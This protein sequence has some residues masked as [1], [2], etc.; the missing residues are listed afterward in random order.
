MK[1]I[2]SLILYI[3]LYAKAQ[4]PLIS[5]N[6]GTQG[7]GNSQIELSNGIGYHN[8]HR[9]TET[10]SEFSGVYSYGVYEKTDLVISIPFINKSTL[11]DSVNTKTAGFSD[12]S[13]EIKYRFLS[14]E[15]FTLAIKPGLSVPT[16]DHESGL[17]AGKYSGSLFLISSLMVNSIIINCNT[18]YMQNNSRCGDATDIWHIS[19]ATDY[20]VSDNF[21]FVFNAGLEKNP[22]NTDSTLPAFGLLGFYYFINGNLELGAGYKNGLTSAETKH[23]FTYSLT[24]RF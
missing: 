19:V 12:L 10:Y 22:D 11:S 8:Q 5:D 4:L 3:P 7:K 16:G 9:C 23:A 6:T 14:H 15:K 18:G 20:S 1:Y 13:L 24:I 2:I 17:G 21:H